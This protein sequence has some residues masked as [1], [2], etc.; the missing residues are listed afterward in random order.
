MK[1]SS[2][3]SAILTMLL[4]IGKIT[5]ESFFNPAY[6]KKYGYSNSYSQLHKSPNA[7]RSAI[8]RLMKKGFIKNRGN[9]YYLTSQGEKKAFLCQLKE[10]QKLNIT[11]KNQ[12]WDKKWRII[13]F[14]IPEK[15]RRHRDALRTMLR[16]VGFKEFQK[17]V[18]V[19]PYKVPDFLKEILFE[20]KIKHH[21]RLITTDDIEYDLDL[22][23][24]F[25]L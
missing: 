25:N 18:W 5:V 24:I 10:N 3:P 20:E 17:S 4:E 22:R 15:K 1:K 13:F 11:N 7:C 8:S 9:I 14:D 16:L 19:Y 12:I 21:T 23:R 2:I 6:A